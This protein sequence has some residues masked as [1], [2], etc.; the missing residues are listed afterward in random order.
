VS[1]PSLRLLREV[2]DLSL[3][4]REG[5]WDPDAHSRLNE[6]LESSDE[7][8]AALLELSVLDAELAFRARAEGFAGIP[9]VVAEAPTTP[10]T[11]RSSRGNLMWW[12][13]G[14]AAA[15]ALA[16]VATNFVARSPDL[17]SLPV[18]ERVPQPVG[19]LGPAENARFVGRQRRPGDAFIEG[20]TLH[21]AEG[22]ARVSMASGV[23]FV[24]QAPGVIEFISSKRVRLRRGVLTAQAAKWGSGFVVETD[25][26]RVTDLGTRFVVSAEPDD[27]ETVVLQGQVRVEPLSAVVDG[28]RSV[29]LSDGESLRVDRGQKS[30]VRLDADEHGH[31][32]EF[33]DFR[34]FKPIAVH[35]TGVGMAEGDED[36]YWRIASGPEGG[37]YNGPQFAVVCVPDVR[38]AGNE[39]TRS[40]WISTAV[41]VRPGGLPRSTFTYETEFD[42]TGF[43]LSTVTVSAQILADNGV[44][45]VRINGQETP[46]EPWDDNEP[47]QQFQRNRFRP[48]EIQHGFV[49]GVN[50]LEID[51]WNGVY[52]TESIKADPNPFA[53]RVEFQAFGRLLDGAR[54]AA[55]STPPKV[56]DDVRSWLQSRAHLFLHKPRVAGQHSRP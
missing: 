50:K 15:A 25:A 20:E 18:V 2:S 39:P 41:D 47:M 5:R 48:V 23:D 36:P 52:Q 21:L 24:L 14:M 38:Y 27:V 26:M 34:P 42:L 29:L 35:N 16:F 54:L 9:A 44:R 53:L 40:Q 1:L 6:L 17:P 37:S 46:I 51:V 49:P 45:S 13:L 55:V 8:C 7:A 33:E 43:D 12:S 31:R 22:E 28:R 3:A 30:S 10:T 4:A 11:R 19:S 32:G 56:R